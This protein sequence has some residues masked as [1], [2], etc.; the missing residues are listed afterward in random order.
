MVRVGIISR[1]LFFVTFVCW[2]HSCVLAQKDLGLL[3]KLLVSVPV[4]NIMAKPQALRGVCAPV[5]RAGDVSLLTTQALFCEQMLLVD[6]H[7]EWYKVLLLEQMQDQPDGQLPVVRG[8]IEKDKTIFVDSFVT[9]NLVVCTH[10]ARLLADD[11]TK[12]TLSLGTKFFGKKHNERL[13]RVSLPGG[14]TGLLKTRDV[15]YFGN[16]KLVAADVR[17]QLVSLAKGMR[18]QPF[19]W[20]GRSSYCK[21]NKDQL[22]SVGCDGLV[23]VLY[24]ACGLEI[25]RFAHEQCLQGKPLDG[26]DLKPGDLIF[27]ASR[28]KDFQAHHA[29]IY[30]G[31]NQLLEATFQSSAPWY[32]ARVISCVQRLKKPISA[33]KNG[34]DFGSYKVF[35]ASYL[36]SKRTMQRLRS[37]A[38]KNVMNFP[39]C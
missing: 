39:E 31:S 38:Q 34:E 2:Q 6:Q 16:K 30:L 19:C 22:T 15:Y 18:G 33:I 13:W 5:T 37:V 27:F 21:K 28:K 8:W 3:P 4:A 1:I 35:F 14:V 7:D 26:E 9:Y 10:N 20:F 25:P 29:M 32:P 17:A 11:G 23:N 36:S 24:R 12:I